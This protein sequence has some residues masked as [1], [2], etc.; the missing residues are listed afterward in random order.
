LADEFKS[1]PSIFLFL[2]STKAMGLGLN[3][4]AANYVII[5]DVDWNP[6]NDSQAQG[7]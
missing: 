4:T 1:N 3:L 7:T 5:F 2:L 6:S